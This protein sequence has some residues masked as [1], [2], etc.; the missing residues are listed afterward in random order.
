MTTTRTETAPVAPKTGTRPTTTGDVAAR[1]RV[2]ST[3]PTTPTPA[4]GLGRGLYPAVL[5]AADVLSLAG[6]VAL[7]WWIRFASGLL[8]TPFG[9]PSLGPYVAT[10]PVLVPLGLAVYHEAGLYRR[11]RP[12]G[13]ARD[14]FAAG[15][16]A[17]TLGLVLA[18]VAFFYRDFSFSRTFL[19]MYVVALGPV[20]AVTRRVAA[21]IQRSLRDH[22]VAVERLAIAG[23]S[24]IGDRLAEN[25]AARPASG[26][27]LVGRL[28]GEEWAP[29]DQDSAGALRPLRL[30]SFLRGHRVDRLLVADPDLTH[31]ER[32]D[33]VEV[34]HELG[35]RCEFVPDLFEVMTGRV[36][37]DEIDGIPLV[38]SRLHPL[39]RVD[40]VKKRTL[41]LL[42]SATGLLALSPLF[43]LL[44]L[45]VRVD[46]RG[47]ILF[48]QRR[49]GRDGTEFDILKFRTM[50]VD[51]EQVSGPV[52]ATKGDLRPTRIGRVL[53][54]TSLDELPQLW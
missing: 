10:L 20:T 7:T 33:L 19:V 13:L 9:V 36:R 43:A 42:G 47:P 37:V 45:L 23:D 24:S 26:L 53:R 52:R 15:R 11:H 34:C 41:D 8:P 39:D 38:G 50:P 32:L 25:I 1:R 28:R 35:A 29:R 3:P 31:E 6:A 44:A 14:F 27:A 2:P 18:A 51:A 4:P 49:L 40:R 5:V 48:R 54:R 46:S 21:R 12:S 16:A 22:A 30:R 17:L